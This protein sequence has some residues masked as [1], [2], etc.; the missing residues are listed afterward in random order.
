MKFSA[1]DSHCHL[2][3]AA[4]AADLDI[5]LTRMKNAGVAA[6]A[7]GTN[8][9][10]SRAAVELAERRAD[11]W[12]S[13]AV[14][15]GHVYEPHH[16]QMELAHPPEEEMFDEEKF[17]SLLASS[18]V[19]AIGETGL[20]YYRLPEEESVRALIKERQRKNFII[21]IR[22]AKARNLPLILHIRE[23][24]AEAL[25]ILREEKYFNGVM[26]CFT[27]TVGEA[28][29]ALSLGLYISFTGAATYPPKKGQTENPLHEVIRIVPQSRLLI[30]TDAPYLTPV[31]HRG[32]RNEPVNVL[33]TAK[34]MAEIRGEGYVNILEVSLNNA[35]RLFN[36][37]A[38]RKA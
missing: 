10:S 26:H 21:Q 24:H 12:A 1:I 27:G 4:Y 34:K 30:E 31:P 14:H 8:Y 7:V 16:D 11:V 13:V 3:A 19:V 9:P 28:R 20:D 33:I 38:M 29:E 6:I 25:E 37:A 32:E 35:V 15:P 22:A 23:A 17:A 18:K 2:Q 36:L 5:V